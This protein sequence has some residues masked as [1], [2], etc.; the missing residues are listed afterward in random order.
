VGPPQ[1]RSIA[2]LSYYADLQTGDWP[3]TAIERAND[4]PSLGA[5]QRSAGILLDAEFRF[6]VENLPDYL[7]DYAHLGHMSRWPG[8]V[9]L[10]GL[11]AGCKR[12]QVPGVQQGCAEVFGADF[13]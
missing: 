7:H 9:Y 3:Q 1:L 8:Q 6:V 2:A 10:S 13:P 11:W 5:R 4:S 12:T